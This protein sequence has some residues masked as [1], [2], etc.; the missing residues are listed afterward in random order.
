[1]NETQRYR[2]YRKLERKRRV[3][4]LVNSIPDRTAAMLLATMF[5]LATTAI[6][7][8][9]YGIVLS[10]LQLAVLAYNP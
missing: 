3:R 8:L 9:A 6:V 5:V 4:K 1:M 2:Q 7:A 10:V